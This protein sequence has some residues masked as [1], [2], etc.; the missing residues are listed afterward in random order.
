[1]LMSLY[2]ASMAICRPHTTHDIHVG[3]LH[4]YGTRIES[5]HMHVPS[6]ARG[7]A[8]WIHVVW[9]N[10][11]GSEIWHLGIDIIH[12]MPIFFMLEVW[13]LIGRVDVYRTRIVVD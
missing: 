6:N 12:Y 2:P 13:W 7:S 9:L 4:V 11:I 10:S 1:M 8:G 5:T 3:Y